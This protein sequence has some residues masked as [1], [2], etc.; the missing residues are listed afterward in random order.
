MISEG[1]WLGMIVAATTLVTSTVA[2]VTMAIVTARQTRADKKADWARQDAV[3]KK[4]E[5]AA[6][7]LL[8]ANERVAE[9]TRLT[10]NK[11]DVIH[12]LVNSQMTAAMQAELD[13]TARELAMMQEVITLKEVAGH[14][15]TAEAISAVESTR[16]K[17]AELRAR[18]E[19]RLHAAP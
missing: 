2:P 3:A 15:P 6:A 16:A 18:I 13:A 5:E 12:T 7:L 17:L 19:D 14:I 1:V 8:K 10:Q 9:N 4:A 11:L